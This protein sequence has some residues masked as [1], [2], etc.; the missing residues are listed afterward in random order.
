MNEAVAAEHQ[1]LLGVYDSAHAP[2]A[3]VDVR[4]LRGGKLIAESH[5]GSDG[6][7]TVA[8]PVPGKY[9]VSASLPG[10]DPVA[11][12]FDLPN[13]GAVSV[14]IVLTQAATHHESID[15]QDTASP[16]EE[17]SPAAQNVP[18]TAV[19][20]LPSRPATV[21]D[22]LPLVPGVTRSPEGGLQ[23]SGGGEHRSALIVN[24]A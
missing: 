1:V 21:A 9:T 24:S 23:I 7:L 3:A 8:L 16:V 2:C 20:N 11:S 19:K 17:G 10:F 4:V 12:E 15:V 5:T 14:E 22:A 6:R 18:V 13:S